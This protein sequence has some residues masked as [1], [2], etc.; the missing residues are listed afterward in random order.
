MPGPAVSCV[1]RSAVD[2]GVHA[3]PEVLDDRRRRERTDERI[4]REHDTDDVLVGVVAP[5]GAEAAGPPVASDRRTQAGP[6]NLHTDAETPALR[7]VEV[8]PGHAWA[9]ADLV[10]GHRLDS[11]TRKQLGTVG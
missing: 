7:A 11:G 10:G 5:G 9:S 1:T 8:G 3:G 4:G 6:A 2:R